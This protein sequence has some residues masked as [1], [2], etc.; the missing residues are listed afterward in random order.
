MAMTGSISRTSQEDTGEWVRVVARFYS[1]VLVAGFTLVPATLIAYLVWFQDPTVVFSNFAFHIVAITI[2]TLEG[3]FVSYVS[4]RC[5]DSSGEPFL[6]WLTLGFLGFT[7]VYSLHGLFTPLAPHHVWLFLLYG[8]ASRLVMAGC[9][10]GAIASWTDRADPPEARRRLSFWGAWIAGFVAVNIAVGV[11]AESPIASNPAVRMS[12]EGGALFLCLVA[13]ATL[14]LRRITAPLMRFYFI[15]IMFFA[16]SSASFLLG[17]IW[18]HQWW[19]AHIIFA[20]GF[21][22]LSFG[23]VRAFLTTR[24]FATVYSEEQMMRELADARDQAEAANRAK[25]DFLA[26]MSHEIRTP[27]NAVVGLSRLALTTNLDPQQHDYVKKIFHAGQSLLGIINDILD[28]SKIDAGKL[29]MERIRF[30][31]D[32]VFNSL[33]TFTAP[34]A[35]DKGLELLFD[36]ARVRGVALLGDPLRLGQVLLNLVVNAIKFTNTGEIVVGVAPLRSTESEAELEFTVRD[37]GIG[38][39]AEQCARLF[40]PFSQADASTTRGY[41]GTGLGLA[42]TKR[43][44]E[45]MGGTIRV[46]SAPDQGSVFTFTAK[47]GLCLPEG[48]SGRNTFPPGAGPLR[49]LIVDDVASSRHV[50]EEMLAPPGFAVTAVESGYAALAALERA[51]QDGMFYDLVLMDWAMPGM[52]GLEAIRQIR[53]TAGL[54]RLPAVVMVTGYER[55]LVMTRALETKIDAVMTKPFVPSTLFDTLNQVLGSG[56]RP[57]APDPDERWKVKALPSLRGARVLVAEDNVVNQ[58]IMHDLLQMAGLEAILAI[59][60]EEAVR[61]AQQQH[62]DAVLMDVHMPVMD[63]YQATAAIRTQPGAAKLPIIAMTA[64]AMAGEREKCLDAGMNDHVTKPVDPERLFQILTN[65]VRLDRPEPAEPAP[66][67]VAPAP[68]RPTAAAFDP[69]LALRFMGGDRGSLGRV[70]KIF[71]D[72]QANAAERVAA[73][74]RDGDRHTAGEVLHGLRGAASTLG[75]EDLTQASLH[76]EEALGTESEAPLFDAFKASLEGALKAIQTYMAPAL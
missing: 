15:A 76:L 3:L 27:M 57:V 20:S 40:K 55:E 12:M 1:H 59:N 21:F 19:L 31:L 65:W 36:V 73:L 69:S 75:I 41:G 29:E 44:V 53:E 28:F 10:L 25:G 37:S 61:L 6:C 74:L 72:G 11:L 2:A 26:N 22:I 67:P 38:M 8:P 64:S 56:P 35:H 4:W 51:A 33:S 32:Q 62:F 13:A 47:F 5:Y 58:V 18:N 42:I 30:D 52:D 49:V 23:V 24:A 9:L 14:L 17:K 60:G 50:L 48:A 54:K 43:L 34:Q 39:T 70:L 46:E 71:V 7:I 45:M 16:Q 63:G 68:A 66:A